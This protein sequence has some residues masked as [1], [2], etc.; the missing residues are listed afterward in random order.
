MKVMELPYRRVDEQLAVEVADLIAA[1]GVPTSVGAAHELSDVLYPLIMSRRRELWTREAEA[2]TRVFPDMQVAGMPDYPL[3]ATRKMVLRAAGLSPKP[4]IA[5]VEDYDPVT[6]S[7]QVKRVAPYLMPDDER[8]QLEVVRRVSSAAGRHAKQASRDTVENT[9]YRNNAGWARVLTGAENC[10]FCAMLASRG[11]VYSKDTATKKASGSSYHDHCDCT[12]T[13]VKPGHP[14]EGK[15]QF[16]ELSALWHS[17]GDMST[18]GELFR[19]EYGFVG[20]A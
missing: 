18:F 15:Q 19:K 1:F 5:R 20:A 8:M 7:M 3:T 2:I 16:K 14:W 4:Q 10:A 6:Q 13:L 9:A 17:T 12:A 11:A